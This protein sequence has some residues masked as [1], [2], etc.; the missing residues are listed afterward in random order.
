MGVWAVGGR[1][2]L[3]RDWG[4]MGGTTERDESRR[5]SQMELARPMT[6]PET[7]NDDSGKLALTPQQS[8]AADLLAAG[9]SVTDAAESIGVA[10][11][12]VSGWLHNDRV[13]QAALNRRRDELWSRVTDR[14]R[15]LLPKAIAVLEREMDQG[16]ASVSAALHVIRAC[17]QYAKVQPIGSSD[18]DE[19]DL[20]ARER[21]A[22]NFQRRLTS[23]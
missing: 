2:A 14:L 21:E 5:C 4:R 22:T 15:A 16:A 7:T 18:P 3:A 23:I 10:R 20:V 6:R 13:F 12:T 17:A 19:L 11:Q 8:A 1:L 9:T